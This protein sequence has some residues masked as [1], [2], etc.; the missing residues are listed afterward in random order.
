MT[1]P[2]SEEE[3]LINFSVKITSLQMKVLQMASLRYGKSIDKIVETA[4]ES[5][6]DGFLI[7]GSSI[8]RELKTK[9]K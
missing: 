9:T 6:A 3:T 4:I 5:I 2:K 7:S 8:P 1:K